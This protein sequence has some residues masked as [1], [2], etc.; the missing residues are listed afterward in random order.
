MADYNYNRLVNPFRDVP[1]PCGMTLRVRDLRGDRYDQC[2]QFLLGFFEKL[3]V[4]LDR[5]PLPDDL[6]DRM[7]AM[8]MHAYHHAS[9]VEQPPTL[10]DDGNEVETPPKIVYHGKVGVPEFLSLFTEEAI[11]ADDIDGAGWGLGDWKA[12][13]LALWEDNQDP[14]ALWLT[15]ARICGMF[16]MVRQQQAEYT[17]RLL[18]LNDDSSDSSTAPASTPETAASPS[19]SSM[20]SRKSRP[21]MNS[22]KPQ[23]SR[24]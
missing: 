20:P 22:G 17:A 7:P 15:D 23:K 13:W 16:A 21:N 19:D 2:I 4:L 11:S 9:I 18:R 14:F 24:S 10:D 1:L 8:L 6:R 12:I 5:D 3:T